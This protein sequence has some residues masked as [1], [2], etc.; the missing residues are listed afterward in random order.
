MYS[1]L[2]PN[3]NLSLVAAISEYFCIVFREF[4]RTHY[5]LQLRTFPKRRV[6]RDS[7]A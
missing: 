3:K 2:S 7:P 1:V 4:L 6:V 5:D